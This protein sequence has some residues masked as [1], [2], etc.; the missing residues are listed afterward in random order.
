M[1]SRLFLSVFSVLIL[2][3]IVALTKTHFQLLF[4]YKY[5]LFDGQNNNGLRPIDMSYSSQVRECINIMVKNYAGPTKEATDNDIRRTRKECG[6]QTALAPQPVLLSLD[7]GGIRGLV[8]V[9]VRKTIL[10]FVF[11]L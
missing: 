2:H 11:H 3:F 8:M 6:T 9:R 10:H 1:L 4:A 7:G 5:N